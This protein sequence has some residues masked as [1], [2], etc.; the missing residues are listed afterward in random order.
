MRL[1][2]KDRIQRLLRTLDIS[3]EILSSNDMIPKDERNAHFTFIE[4]TR[5]LLLN[6]EPQYENSKSLEFVENAILT[7]WNE[8]S[9]PHIENFWATL[10][11][12]SISFI[13]RDVI[14]EVLNR[15]K[16]KNI[17][18]FDQIIDSFVIAQQTGRMSNTEAEKMN[19]Y[20]QE[21][22]SRQKK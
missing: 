19:F 10:E 2:Y 14:R 21:F 9:G 6:P 11:K 1:K 3:K 4:Q 16:I 17:H 15:K 18:E 12:E 13:R 8:A 5:E 22:E 7:Y 20:I